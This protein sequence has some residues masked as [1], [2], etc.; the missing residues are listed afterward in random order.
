MTMY[1]ESSNSGCIGPFGGRRGRLLVWLLLGALFPFGARAEEPGPDRESAGPPPSGQ[2]AAHAIDPVLRFKRDAA[3]RASALA[4]QGNGTAAQSVIDEV[5]KKL[6]AQDPFTEELQG[7]VLTV[8]KDY[9]GAE[10]SFRALLQKAPDSPVGQFNLAEVLFVQGRY[11]EA[12]KWFAS[13]ESARRAADPKV[14]DL[15]RY[16]RIVC[17]LADGASDG[18]EALLADAGPPPSGPANPAVQYARAAIR[19]TQRDL[20]GATEAI[21]QARAQFSPDVENLYVD[22]LVELRWGRRAEDGKFE[23]LSPAK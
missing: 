19:F 3:A 12:E 23:F 13:V 22:S 4:S 9:P 2:S 17:R 18:A 16:K 14:A 5:R 7:T 21:G 11:G 10:A 1:E 15:C 6:G 20:S 8:E